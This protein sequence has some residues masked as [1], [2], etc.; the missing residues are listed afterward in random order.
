MTALIKTSTITKIVPE[1]GDLHRKVRLF[2]EPVVVVDR[3]RNISL[4]LTSSL[5]YI[6][7]RMGL[8]LGLGVLQLI[9]MLFSRINAWNQLQSR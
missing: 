8:Y 4:D 2:L 1:Y 9:E 5:G 7:S 6:G 3:V